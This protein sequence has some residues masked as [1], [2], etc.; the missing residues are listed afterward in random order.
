MDYII[1][2]I[3][4]KD[5]KSILKWKY[6]NPYDLYNMNDSEECIFEL[7]QG[8]YYSV[9]QK[10][11]LIG[12]F[13]FGENA[14]IP[15]KETMGLYNDDLLDIG[16]GLNPVLVDKGLGYT[17]LNAGLKF[18]NNKFN[19]RTFRLTVAQFNKRAIKV[20]KKSSFKIVKSFNR[21]KD[22]TEFYIM[23]KTNI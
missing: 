5:T 17:F 13:C 2:K 23:T 19:Q 9:R 1:D 16:L 22:D 20:Y 8:T 7:M 18:A 10:D 21:K 4:L 12:F 6:P 11:E 3:N 15:I 14:Q